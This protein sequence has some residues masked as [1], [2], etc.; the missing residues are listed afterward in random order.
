MNKKTY[1]ILFVIGVLASISFST[2]HY[3]VINAGQVTTEIQKKTGFKEIDTDILFAQARDAYYAGKIIKAEE[4][5]QAI[6]LKESNNL[7]ALKNIYFINKEL[8]NLKESI[9]SLEKI[10]NLSDDKKWNYRLGLSYFQV[11]NYEQAA[12]ILNKLASEYQEVFSEKELAIINYYL[13]LISVKNKDLE[14][15]KDFFEKGINVSPKTTI[16]YVELAGI[17]KEKGQYHDAITM[18]KKALRYDYS[19]SYIYPELAELY[20][21][22]SEVSN[23]YY[24]WKRSLSTNNKPTLASDKI[25]KLEEIHPELIELEKEEKNRTRTSINWSIVEPITDTADIPLIR[26]G[27]IEKAENITFQAG[28]NFKV[29]NNDQAVF[30][31]QAKKEYTLKHKNDKFEIYSDGEILSNFKTDKLLLKLSDDHYTF[32]LYDISFGKGYFWAGNED[33]QYRGELEILS[34]DNDLLTVINNINLEEYL[35]SV[36]PAEMPASWP[37]EALKAQAIAA[38]SYAL[39]HLGRHS[40]QGYDLCATV[41]CAAYNGV[42]SENTRTT[43]AVLT[44]KGEVINYNNQIVDAVFS[45]NSGGYSESSADVWGNSLPYLKGANNMME[46]NYSFPLEPYQLEEWLIDNPSSFSGVAKYIGSNVYRWV[47]YM[48]VD[49]FKERYNLTELINIIPEGR[50][51]GGSIQSI[52]IIGDND[53]EIRV[54]KDSIRGSFGGLKSNR[55]FIDKIYDENGVITAVLFFGGGWG[56]NVGMDQTAAAGM[57]EQS[58]SYENILKHFYK[59]TKVIKKY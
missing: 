46:E 35:L 39:V 19:L 4:L 6:N 5:Y 26:V 21:Q 29:F 53:K 47:K 48:P 27:L 51:I 42:K 38:R 56:H 58:Y 59:N 55:F 25:D 18:Y 36:V 15:A 7:T 37:M 31:G 52:L 43:E 1:L 28:T 49:Y 24:Y 8:G 40:R 10:V 50:S 33:R 17:H 16:N 14:L 22:L 3:Y 32:D 57:A 34:K 12:D 2:I 23:S 44:T 54:K 41:H 20:E 9:T 13:G 45:S 11:G 30:N